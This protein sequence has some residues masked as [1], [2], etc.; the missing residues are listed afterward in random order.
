MFTNEGKGLVAR[1][2]GGL[3]DSCIDYLAIGIG[4]RPIPSTIANVA[5]NSHQ[6]Q[7]MTQMVHEVARVPVISTLPLSD[8]RIKCIA[9]LPNDLNCE[10]TEVALWT[11]AQNAG[12]GH[13]PTQVIAAFDQTENWKYDGTT[14]LLTKTTVSG[15]ADFAQQEALSSTM[16]ASYSPYDDLLW[17][18][19]P[20]RRTNKEGFRLSTHGILLRSNMSTIGSGWPMSASGGNS[21]KRSVSGL[22][23][24]TAGPDDQLKLS[25]FITAPAST[26][27]PSSVRVM[28]WFKTSDN[29]YAK[30]HFK[31]DTTMAAGTVTT[32]SGSASVT[33][34][35][36]TDLRHGDI[37]WNSSAMEYPTQF[38]YA[39]GSTTAGT[40][41][42]KGGKTRTGSIDVNPI[43]WGDATV[44]SRNNSYFTQYTKLQNDSVSGK[45][46]ITYDSGFLWANVSEIIVYSEI[47]TAGFYLGLDALSFVNTDTANPGYGMV[48]YDIAKNYPT[49]GIVTRQGSPTSVVFEVQIV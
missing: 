9:E 11:H 7:Y 35:A 13:P 42:M 10:F 16:K 17:T 2:V 3:T 43:T 36:D 30:W 39:D 47:S 18:M 29:K 20:D 40:L 41:S 44:K 46:D 25:Y 37:L 45:T 34:S 27:P 33:L 24:D 48:A 23:F 19:R 15:E 21:I 26:T 14:D 12:S 32:T 22:P 31:Q 49:R 1:K 8:G 28:V 4:G 38:F 5:D 6:S